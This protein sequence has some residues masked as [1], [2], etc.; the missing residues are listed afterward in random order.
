[1]APPYIYLREGASRPPPQDDEGP[2]RTLTQERK[3]NS[4]LLLTEEVEILDT[5]AKYYQNLSSLG[6]DGPTL[7]EVTAHRLFLLSLLEKLTEGK[8]KEHSQRTS[9]NNNNSATSTLR[10][11][12]LVLLPN[13]PVE[14]QGAASVFL[15]PDSPPPPDSEDKVRT[16][17]FYHNPEGVGVADGG[18]GVSTSTENNIS[19][20]YIFGKR[21]PPA[22]PIPTPAEVPLGSNTEGVS[23]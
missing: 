11:G 14:G 1:M 8:S 9:N 4:S 7:E 15:T 21:P 17:S 5:L 23:A 3:I 22:M 18:G 13:T 19:S 6:Q 16:D 12:S 10:Q 2:G 20:L